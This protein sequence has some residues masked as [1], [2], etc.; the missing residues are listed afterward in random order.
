MQYKI[1]QFMFQV[2][3]SGIWLEAVILQPLADTGN[4]QIFLGNGV[5][6]LGSKDIFH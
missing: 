6:D 1:L 3:F 5:F 2:Q 4:A